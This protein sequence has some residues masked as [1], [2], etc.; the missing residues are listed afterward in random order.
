MLFVMCGLRRARTE[1][2]YECNPVMGYSKITKE[3]YCN[4]INVH[5]IIF[6]EN[7]Q[8]KYYYC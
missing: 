5:L 1:P 7:V 3:C 8:Y 4:V 6:I 2:F